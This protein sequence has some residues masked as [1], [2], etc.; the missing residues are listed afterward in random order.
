MRWG[1]LYIIHSFLRREEHMFW[2]GT[3]TGVQSSYEVKLSMRVVGC[4]DVD[5]PR[6]PED[7][8]DEEE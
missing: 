4:V 3:N 7:D 1:V 6:G 8:E 5:E 2:Q